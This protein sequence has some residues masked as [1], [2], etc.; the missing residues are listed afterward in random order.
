MTHP[1]VFKK[2]QGAFES[3]LEKV[4][5]EGSSRMEV[6][7][8]IEGFNALTT[9]YWTFDGTDEEFRRYMMWLFKLPG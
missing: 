7:W 6:S 8:K 3:P 9:I 5:A 1:S 2:F 4:K